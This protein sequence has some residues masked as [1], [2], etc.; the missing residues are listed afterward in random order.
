M[1]SFICP[2]LTV[3]SNVEYEHL[4]KTQQRYNNL[5]DS[6]P[7]PFFDLQQESHW[8]GRNDSIMQMHACVRFV[9][10]FGYFYW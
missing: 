3:T 4:M 2:Q 1:S 8:G 10:T 6:D 9:W 7:I 5:P